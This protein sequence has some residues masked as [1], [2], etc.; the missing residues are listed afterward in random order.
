MTYKMDKGLTVD[1]QGFTTLADSR[2]WLSDIDDESTY[3]EYRDWCEMNGIGYGE[4]DSEEFVRWCIDN[5]R[6]DIVDLLEEA[7]SGSLEGTYIITGRLGLWNGH[8]HIRLMKVSG[9]RNALRM[10]FGETDDQK[11]EISDDGKTIRISAMHHDGT[12]SF[13]VRA[14]AD[15]TAYLDEDELMD[16]LGDYGQSAALPEMARH[17]VPIRLYN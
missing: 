5:S 13:E 10:C 6:A 11:V 2:S 1:A 16:T 17:F 15:E 9:L 4:K 14:L 8:P 7:G 12:N 3:E